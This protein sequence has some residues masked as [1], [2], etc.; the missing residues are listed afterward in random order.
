VAV[1]KLGWDYLDGSF[2][3]SMHW[4]EMIKSK[5]ALVDTAVLLE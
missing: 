3:S 5:G 4:V 1:L 2:N